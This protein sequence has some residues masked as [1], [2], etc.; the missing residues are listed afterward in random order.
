MKT[1]EEKIEEFLNELDFD[2]NILDYISAEEIES[3]ED[4]EDYLTDN[5]IFQQEGE[6][7]YYSNAIS[8]LNKYDNS[9]QESLSL[10]KGMGLSIESLNSEI[11]ASL[12]KEEMLRDEFAE[13]R[14]EIDDFLFDVED[15]EEEEEE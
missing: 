15:D 10:A 4:I 11:L 3:V 12:L 8:F 13:V 1:R 14:D 9:L 2:I 7:I 5:N 6:I